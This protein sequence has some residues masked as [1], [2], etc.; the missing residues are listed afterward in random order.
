MKNLPPHSAPAPDCVL[1]D[2]DGTLLDTAPDL[3]TALNR[4]RRERGVREPLSAEAVRPTV[5]HGS[6]GML[7]L[8]FGLEPD[9]PAYAELNQRLLELYRA[10]IAIDTALFPGMSEVLSHLETHG[11]HWGVV[12]NKPGW[13]T[14]PLLEALDLRARAA[15]VVSGDTLAKRKPDP[16]P[17]L[18]ACTTVGAAPGRSWYVG[19]AERDVRAGNQAGLTTL[20]AR[21]G[22]LGAEDR[23]EEWG[24][25]GFLEQPADLLNWLGAPRRAV[26]RG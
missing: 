3:A 19:D 10:A 5:S 26:R 17:L 11:I 21:F 6:P 16:E 13:L 14:E 23:P 18:Y 4:L 7:K 20:V 9:D 24:A 2:L 1:F 12:T 25:H 15:C 8:G 22:Y